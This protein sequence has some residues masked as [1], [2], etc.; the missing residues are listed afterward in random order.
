MP[1]ERI[2]MR[3]F[4]DTLRLRYD[5]KLSYRQIAACLK[6]SVGVI[7]KYLALAAAAGLSWPLPDSMDDA[8]ISRAVMLTPASPPGGAYAEPDYAAIHTQLKR[9]GVTLRLLW[10]EYRQAHPE[11]GYQFTQF[12]VRF[13]QWQAHLTCS[14]RQ[15]YRAAEK[16]FVD[17]SGATFPVLQVG[18]P[19][20]QAEIF[21]AVL[22]A[23]RLTY[24]EATWTQSMPDW[25]GAH[26]RCF[27]YLGGVP[28]LLVPDCLK[29]AVTKA[30]RYD[31]KLNRTYEEMAGHYGTAILPARPRHPKDKAPAENGVLL[32]QRWILA[33]LRNQSFF[34][35]AEL[36][37][38]IAVL[39]EDL[40]ARPFKR[41]PGSRRSLFDE[42]ERGALRRLP[43]EPYAY[44]E[45]TNARVGIDY[46]VD[47]G[48]HFYSVPHRLVRR[49]VEARL[50]ESIV[51]IFHGG[52][53]V[54]SHPR[55]HRVGEHSTLPEHM[56]KA[57][58][59]HS[60]WTPARLLAWA[61][62]CGPSTR[63][64]IAHTLE[65]KPHP[66]HGYRVCLGLKRLA[67]RYGEDRLEAACR[68]S[69]AIHA[70]TYASIESI[71]K[72]G[73]DRIPM[74]G[75]AEPEGVDLV[76]ENVR[77]AEYYSVGKDGEEVVRC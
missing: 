65:H 36:N 56:P 35:L 6:L 39:L 3:K 30:C 61:G 57:H 66:E 20:R 29:S 75:E 63:E 55:S 59:E 11:D 14:M 40:N 25:V 19:A 45:W 31:P 13:R 64:V 28:E 9:K 8:A 52:A 58:R 44:G 50:T 47:L 7:S 43:S 42:I 62:E 33:K 49:G 22:G 73:L 46:H 12:T 74:A 4:R 76:H 1:R 54:A 48:G 67:K 53:R 16:L 77:G 34:S 37:A 27:V 23:S 51:A 24:A 21:I 5:A 10:E 2:S 71:L 26:G 60:E 17:F 41:L 32:V 18:G 68:R 70:P 38:A 69:V 15:T 72:L